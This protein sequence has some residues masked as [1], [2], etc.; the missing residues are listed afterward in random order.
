MRHLDDEAPI[1]PRSNKGRPAVVATALGL[2]LVCVSLSVSAGRLSYQ[3]AQSDDSTVLAAGSTTKGKPHVGP[4]RTRVTSSE[5][6]EQTADLLRAISGPGEAGGIKI[7]KRARGELIEK[8]KQAGL[9]APEAAEVI[10]TGEV[11]K[12]LQQ[13]IHGESKKSRAPLPGAITEALQVLDCKTQTLTVTPGGTEKTDKAKNKPASNGEPKKSKGKHRATKEKKP[14]E[15]KSTTAAPSGQ[16][17]ESREG[18]GRVGSLVEVPS[19]AGAGEEYQ[20]DDFDVS[21]SLGDLVDALNPLQGWSLKLFSV[22][23]SVVTPVAP[24]STEEVKVLVTTETTIGIT[25]NTE[26]TK[27]LDEEAPTLVTQAVDSE[28][29]EE[30][31]DPIVAKAPNLDAV[32]AVAFGQLAQGLWEAKTEIRERD[33]PTS[34]EGEGTPSAEAGSSSAGT[35][36]DVP[37]DDSQ[38][39]DGLSREPLGDLPQHAA[40]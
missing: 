28:T 5:S 36:G 29:G 31:T 37:A 13:H 15:K 6:D 10:D 19:S 2:G 12:S 9:T 27:Q 25:V 17:P 16:G 34:Q 24:E 3:T 18:Q 20:D 8:L 33:E 7:S 35:Q 14:K 40:A 23:G 26:I 1:R 38:T 11:P 4:P 22:E 32:S 21:D 30:L 39:S